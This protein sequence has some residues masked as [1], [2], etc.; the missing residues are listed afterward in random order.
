MAKS[1]FILETS[2][3]NNAI[4]NKERYNTLIWFEA[5]TPNIPEMTVIE[6]FYG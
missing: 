3:G 1:L 2:V 6:L 5:N 4:S